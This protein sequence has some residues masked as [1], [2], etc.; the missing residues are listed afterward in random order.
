MSNEDYRFLWKNK[1]IMQ[2]IQGPFVTTDVLVKSLFKMSRVGKTVFLKYSGN[3]RASCL[4]LL[5]SHIS[6]L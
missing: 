4:I 3:H 1:T 2:K 6:C 5:W